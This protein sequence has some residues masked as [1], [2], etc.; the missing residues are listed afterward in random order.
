MHRVWQGR[1][2]PRRR[3]RAARTEAQVC[4]CARVRACVVAQC[5]RQ[6]PEAQARAAER[7]PGEPRLGGRPSP[8][9]LASLSSQ[10]ERLGPRAARPRC[11]RH[12][13][14]PPLPSHWMALPPVAAHGRGSREP[15]H[16]GGPPRRRRPIRGPDRRHGP[17]PRAARGSCPVDC[18]AVPPRPVPVVDRT[19][20]AA[21]RPAARAEEG[22]VRAVP[23]P[24]SAAIRYAPVLR[25]HCRREIRYAP[26]KCGDTLLSLSL[27]A[28]TRSLTVRATRAL[29][30]CQREMGG[31]GTLLVTC[32]PP[33]RSCSSSF[34]LLFALFLFNC[35]HRAPLSSSSSEGSDKIVL[36]VRGLRQVLDV[37]RLT[38]LVRVLVRAP[39]PSPR[40]R[41]LSESSSSLVLLCNAP[42]RVRRSAGR[43]PAS[44]DP[45]RPDIRARLT[46]A[47]ARA[48]S[49]QVCVRA[50]LRLRGHSVRR[51][52]PC[53]RPFSLPQI[54]Q[55]FRVGGNGCFCHDRNGSVRR[56]KW[57]LSGPF[58]SPQKITGRS[59]LAAVGPPA[60]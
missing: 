31:G 55:S 56:Q 3:H 58:L 49:R 35:V 36:L 16:A 17:G 53:H 45:G 18:W 26:F 19:P 48:C 57:V 7:D 46:C 50:R 38:P 37:G 2:E 30:H 44:A 39:C 15:S 5:Q 21:R 42:T 4:V 13:K 40:P 24:S 23:R 10:L 1:P 25:A 52:T 34:C 28:V 47:R 8:R 6:T 12:P 43:F 27:I 54:S 32:P 11:P 60:A 20:P 51:P 9:A 33:P 14:G 41:P 22:R 29:S 59:H